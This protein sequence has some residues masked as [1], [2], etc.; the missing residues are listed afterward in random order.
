MC[1]RVLVQEAAKEPG[2]GD[3]VTE[4]GMREG[5]AQRTGWGGVLQGCSGSAWTSGP[6]LAGMGALRC[7][8]LGWSTSRGKGAGGK[9]RGFLESRVIT[10]GKKVEVI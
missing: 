8:A 9:G 10:S 6:V 4:R 2:C 1:I 7:A 3:W 5:P